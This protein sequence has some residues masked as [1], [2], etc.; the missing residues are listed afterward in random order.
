MDDETVKTIEKIMETGAPGFAYVYP[1][2]G[3]PREEYYVSTDPKK[4]ANFIGSK[5]G[6]VEKIV[7][8]DMADQEIFQTKTYFVYEY[9]NETF[10]K[11]LAEYLKSVPLGVQTTEE[12]LAVDKK[13]ADQYFFEEDQKVTGMEYG[14]L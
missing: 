1:L 12:M 6:N 9:S 10:G 3:G 5:I 7:I 13:I 8:T 2:D 11:A 4:L 14:S